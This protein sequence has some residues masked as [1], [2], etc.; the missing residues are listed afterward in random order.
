MGG[1]KGAWF[2][3]VAMI[4][5]IQKILELLIVKD[6]QTRPLLQYDNFIINCSN[7]CYIVAI[8]LQTISVKPNS[9]LPSNTIW[10]KNLRKH[11]LYRESSLKL[12]IHWKPIYLNEFITSEFHVF[13]QKKRKLNEKE[14]RK[15][16]CVFKVECRDWGDLPVLRTSYL[17]SLKWKY[18]HTKRRKS[19]NPGKNFFPLNNT[20]CNDINRF[21]KKNLSKFYVKILVNFTRNFM[22]NFRTIF[23]KFYPIRYLYILR[24]FRE[25]EYLRT[26]SEIRNLVNRGP[27]PK[28]LPWYPSYDRQLGNNSKSKDNSTELTGSCMVNI[29]T[30][31]SNM[32]AVAAGRVV[33][34]FWKWSL[35]DRFCFIFHLF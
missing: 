1:G 34:R 30:R 20:H 25:M 33:N 29:R 14:T 11:S 12:V 4:S 35:N 8:I 23:P 9:L 28:L 26:I 19:K 31:E 24:I 3:L 2:P 21:Y 10:I 22:R 16:E 17:V 6:Q 27:V 18:F 7:Q 13:T 15:S 5:A 32:L